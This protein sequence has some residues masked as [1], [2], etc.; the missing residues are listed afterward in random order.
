MQLRYKFWFESDRGY[1]FG[2]GAYEL[3]KRI[4]EEGSIRK[5]SMRMKLSYR[6]A[7]GMIQEI[8]ENLGFK[9][10]ESL[11]GGRGGGETRLTEEGKKLLRMYEKYEKVFDYVSKHPYIK[12]SITVD[13][14]LVENDSILLI[15]RKHE[16]FRG[17]Y[18]LP[19]GFV[20]YGEKTEDAAVREM[21]EETGLDVEIVRLVGIYSDPHRDPRDHTITVVYEVK[22]RKGDL[23]GGDDAQEA[24]FFPLNSLPPL[25]FDHTKIVRD[26][27]LLR[28]V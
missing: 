24:R 6:H 11:R 8:E 25:A 14:I 12:P 4:E 22:R 1:V 21:K 26:Y 10:V 27:L 9:V 28:G 2:K 5:A 3:L 23:K 19:G 20:E 13:M 17:M 15:K 18:A 7:W 16:P